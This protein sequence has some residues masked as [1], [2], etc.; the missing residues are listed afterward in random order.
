MQRPDLTLLSAGLPTLP[1][2]FIKR[3]DILQTLESLLLTE[4]AILAEGPEGAGKTL[5]I[6]YFAQALQAPVM[7]QFDPIS[8]VTNH[9]GGLHGFTRL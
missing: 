1:P 3:D 8:R 2:H 5:N 4:S 7:T 9:E 6:Q